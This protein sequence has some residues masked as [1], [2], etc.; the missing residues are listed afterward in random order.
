MS[1][2]E[3]ILFPE[4]NL[5]WPEQKAK[6]L[7]VWFSNDLPMTSKLEKAKKASQLVYKVLVEKKGSLPAKPVKKNGC[8]IVIVP[9]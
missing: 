2:S 3:V 5:K 1:N 7:A 4:K 9:R 6:A 8:R